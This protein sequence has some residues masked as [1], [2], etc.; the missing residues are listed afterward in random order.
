MLNVGLKLRVCPMRISFLIQKLI[1]GFPIL[2]SHEI[3]KRPLL[4]DDTIYISVCI[5][6]KFMLII[7]GSFEPLLL[8][9]LLKNILA[10]SFY[11]LCVVGALL[12]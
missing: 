8:D 4:S 2:G 1:S 10:N 11:Q 6:D 12:H 5:I 9:A 3:T 7:Q